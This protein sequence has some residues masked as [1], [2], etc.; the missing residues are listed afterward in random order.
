[1]TL[2][3][4]L[5]MIRVFKNNEKYL[6][7]SVSVK[8]LI[9]RLREVIKFEEETIRDH[10]QKKLVKLSKSDIIEHIK[11]G[12]DFKFNTKRELVSLCKKGKLKPEHDLGF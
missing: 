7:R 2:Y 8:D 4:H 10:I 5:I 3:D 1:M 6:Y 11:R 9:K 12:I